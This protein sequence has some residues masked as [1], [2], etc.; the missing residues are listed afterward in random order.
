MIFFEIQ[1]FEADRSIDVRADENMPLIDL[2]REIRDREIVDEVDI[3]P[4]TILIV[5]KNRKCVLNVGKSLKDLGIVGGD[6]LIF[7]RR[8]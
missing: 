6:T 5:S 3:N 7:I 8:K 4:K 1:I 2:V